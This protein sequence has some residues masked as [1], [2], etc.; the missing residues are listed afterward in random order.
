MSRKNANTSSLWFSTWQIPVTSVL[1]HSLLNKPLQC[2]FV[3][4]PFPETNDA[5]DTAEVTVMFLATRCT[6][7]IVNVRL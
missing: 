5:A 4:S 2:A 1:G 6:Y 7:V 3:C